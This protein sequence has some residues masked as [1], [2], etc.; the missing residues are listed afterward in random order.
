MEDR[1]YWIGF[2]QIR[3]IGSV[4]TKML[5]DYFGDLSE[6][7]KSGPA[8]LRKAGLPEKVVNSFVKMR[9]EI[10]LEKE[11]DLIQQLGISVVTFD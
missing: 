7:W 10:D 8:L 11:W 5:L 3:G 4:R 2:D 9:H 6:A 1:R